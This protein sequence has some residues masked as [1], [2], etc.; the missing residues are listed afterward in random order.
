MP[1]TPRRDLLR[2]ARNDSRFED[3]HVRIVRVDPGAH[4]MR[5][6]CA[7]GLDPRE[8]RQ[9]SAGD[10]LVHLEVVRVA[11]DERPLTVERLRQRTKL[12]DASRIGVPLRSMVLRA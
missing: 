10:R 9:D 2:I 11:V 12:V 6:A 4:P 5:V 3:E 8:V 7:E 1:P